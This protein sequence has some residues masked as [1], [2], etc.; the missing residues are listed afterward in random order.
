CLMRVW[1]GCACFACRLRMLVAKPGDTLA[2]RKAAITSGM[3]RFIGILL[4][5]TK[6]SRASPSVHPATVG[7]VRSVRVATARAHARVPPMSAID[8][9]RRRL[10]EERIPDVPDEAGEKKKRPREV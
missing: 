7:A 3:S 2:A 9:I 1:W 5:D 10:K 8:V 4:L 6:P